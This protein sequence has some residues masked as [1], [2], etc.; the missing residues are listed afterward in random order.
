MGP[1]LMPKLPELLPEMLNKL[2]MHG[3]MDSLPTLDQLSTML[4]NTNWFK[5]N[6]VHHQ[7]IM[8]FLSKHRTISLTLTTNSGGLN[9]MLMSPSKLLLMHGET[10]ILLTQVQNSHTHSEKY[11]IISDKRRNTNHIE[12]RFFK[13]YL[14]NH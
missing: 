11:E 9:K 1:T 3:E 13:V 8:D 6:Q 12:F 2:L 4:N 5:V 10:D 7:L 14:R